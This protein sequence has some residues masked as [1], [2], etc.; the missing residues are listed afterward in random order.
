VQCVACQTPLAEQMRFC[1]ICGELVR[2][3]ADARGGDP[4]RRLLERALADRYELLRV[5]GRGGM[6]VV[7]LARERGLE[8]LVAI[9]VLSPETAS[10]LESRERFRREARTAAKLNHPAIL[11]LYAFGEADD[12]AY[13]VMGYV[14]GESL[15]ELLRQEGRLSPDATRRILAELADALDY[16][17]RHGVVHR[18][19]KPENVLIED[20]SGRAYLADFGIAKARAAA[21]TLTITG[22]VVGTPQYMSPEQAAGGTVDGRSDI[23]SLGVVGYAMLS[24]RVPF[25]G[26]GVREILVRHASQPPPP[27]ETVVPGVPE[28]LAAAIARCLVKDPEDRWPDGKCLRQ[29][30]T[31]QEAA[32]VG[33]PDELREI[34]TFGTW[35]ILWFV[36]WTIIAFAEYTSPADSLLFAILALLVPAGFVLQAWNVARKGFA[37]RRVLRVACWPPKWWGL[38]W[39]RPVRRPDDVWD[40]LP[41]PARLTR[42]ALTAFFAIAPVLKYVERHGSATTKSGVSLTTDFQ[43]GE[44]LLVAATLGIVVTS[45]WRMRRREIPIED[46]ARVLVGPTAAAPFWS[47]ARIKPLLQPRPTM[48][49]CRGV[50]EPAT[51]HDM[52]YAISAAAERLAGPVRAIGTD[53]VAASRQLLGALESV[54]AEIAMLSRDADEREIDRIEQRLATCSDGV[55]ADGDEQQMR[56]LLRRQLELLSRLRARLESAT[57]HRARLVELLRELWLS[58]RSLEGRALELPEQA[59]RVRGLCDAAESEAAGMGSIGLPSPLPL[60]RPPSRTTH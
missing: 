20:E 35:A 44:Y 55:G 50:D 30:L 29:A 10:T 34:A 16:A 19:I 14:R 31:G 32:E 46:V 52:M 11:P 26:R 47:N 41:L 59:E 38:W 53:A 25:E 28:D 37:L 40:C 56:L 33:L 45:L 1:P 7:Y 27:L 54:N 6:G 49:A 60:S 13:L 17:H 9:K 42:L 18:D 2:P 8:R 5:L 51:P 4:I 22:A 58:V 39:P 23:Y 12:L 3:G 43:I 57:E 15:A 21:E 36:V 24:G 48:D